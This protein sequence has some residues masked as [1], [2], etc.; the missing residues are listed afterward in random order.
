MLRVFVSPRKTKRVY[1]FSNVF[2][3]AVFQSAS[4]S[5]TPLSDPPFAVTILR[6]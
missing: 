1:S 3:S 4:V 2:W 5:S 6:W